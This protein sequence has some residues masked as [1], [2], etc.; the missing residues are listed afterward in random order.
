MPQNSLKAPSVISKRM[1][2]RALHFHSA[3]KVKEIYST[4]RVPSLY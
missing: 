3:E 2:V 4:K 1:E